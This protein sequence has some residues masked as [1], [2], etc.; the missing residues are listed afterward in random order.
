LVELTRRTSFRKSK[1]S[2]K[3]VVADREFFFTATK[4]D[5]GVLSVYDTLTGVLVCCTTKSMDF[6][7]K[8]LI[9]HKEELETRIRKYEP[10]QERNLFS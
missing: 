9:A 5:K 3:E 6:T 2:F 8:W 4:K 10:E 7:R 1:S